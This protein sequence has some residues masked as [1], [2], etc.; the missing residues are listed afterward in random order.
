MPK[1]PDAPAG[2]VVDGDGGEGSAD[3]GSLEEEDVLWGK[4]QEQ[5]L[6]HHEGQ[7]SNSLEVECLMPKGCGKER[8]QV[9]IVSP[10][11]LT[12]FFYCGFL[13]ER[14]IFITACILPLSNQS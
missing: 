12:C 10:C 6:E 4:D 11:S 3:D 7:A 5:K 14:G 1:A 2:V 13:Q 9:G 8:C